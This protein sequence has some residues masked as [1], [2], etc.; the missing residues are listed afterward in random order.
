MATTGW[1]FVHGWGLDADFWQPL[2][3]A[4][5]AQPGACG[6]GPQHALDAGYFGAPPHRIDWASASRWIAV[7]HSLGWARAWLGDATVAPPEGWAA[8]VSICGFTRFCATTPGQ[9]GQAQRVVDRMVRAFD[10]DAPTVLRDFLTRCG[11]SDQAPAASSALN[12]PGLRA[13]LVQLRNLDLPRTAWSAVPLL[14][15]AARDD[16]IVSPTLTHDCFGAAPRARLVWH[17]RAGH[18]LG[19]AHAPWCAQHIH[20][21][22]QELP[23]G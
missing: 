4:L 13:D 5:S 7:G 10:L 14:A 6:A 12:T 19:H 20:R 21:F 11:L 2:R 18:A 3:T 22:V 16:A 17:E 8:S 23:H 9:S 15:L 1:V